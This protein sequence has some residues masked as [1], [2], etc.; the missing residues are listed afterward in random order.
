[1]IRCSAMLA[2]LF[3]VLGISPL[4]AADAVNGAQV[5]QR[6]CATCHVVGDAPAATVQQGPPSLRAVAQG[7]TTGDQLRAF[8]SHPHAPM[9]DLSL[10]RSEIDD[11]TAYIETL[12]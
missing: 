6:W 8:L 11:L 7:R 10:T 4:L 5:A 9:P 3:S 12:R 2:L 1:M